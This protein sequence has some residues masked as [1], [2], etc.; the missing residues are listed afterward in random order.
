MSST[1][2]EQEIALYS[3]WRS[4][5]S[6]RVRIVLNLKK[7]KFEYKEINLLKGEQKTEEFL[8]INPNGRIPTLKYGDHYIS[9]VIFI[10]FSKIS[11][12]LQLLNFLKKLLK[13]KMFYQK[14][15]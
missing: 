6:W 10:Y 11:S 15:H 13:E 7:I 14:I 4:T 1:T 2:T 12:H 5:A 8:S 9:E 3:Y